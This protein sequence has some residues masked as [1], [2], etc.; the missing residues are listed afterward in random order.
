MRRR[1]VRPILFWI[2]VAV[3]AAVGLQFVWSIV[4]PRIRSRQVEKAMAHF[5]ANPSQ[6]RA[7]ELVDLIGNHAAT[8]E[9]G[10]RALGLLLR[11]DI[12]TRKRYAA[13]QPVGVNLQR[14]LQLD[15][16]ELLWLDE[17]ISLDEQPVHRQNGAPRQF[18]PIVLTLRVPRIYSQPGTYP[19][20]I[21]VQ[22]ALGIERSNR[23][24]DLVAWC[25]RRVGGSL[26]AMWQPAQTYNCDFTL[27]TEIVVAAQEEAETVEMVSNP[28]LDRAVR[29]AFL[30]DGPGANS[31]SLAL[32]PGSGITPLACCIN[33]Q[34]LPIAVSFQCVR[35]LP[36]G[37]EVPF[38]GWY[39]EQFRAPAG[40]SGSFFVDLQIIKPPPKGDSLGTIVLKPDRELAYMDPTFKTI[41]N[42]TLEFPT[43]STAAPSSKDAQQGNGSEKRPR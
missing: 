26:G 2:L 34:N 14:M 30:M 28:D 8:A 38:P 19:L 31:A 20:E 33:Y 12:V 18:R 41:W 25:M 4:G 15:F 27:R 32:A 3:V 40:S 16:G 10:R 43:H 36:D 5:Q 17:T 11:P 21:R 42:G 24:G 13:G 39:P 29:K 1:H 7:T 6:A 35:R 9:Q 37:R 23:L 22:C